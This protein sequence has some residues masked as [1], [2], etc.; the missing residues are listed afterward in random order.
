MTTMNTPETIDQSTE[1]LD[2]LEKAIR[3]RRCLRCGG[4]LFLSRI[5]GAGEWA[6]LQCGRTYPR[7]GRVRQPAGL[8]RPTR[9][10]A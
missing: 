2:Q 5:N 3:A 10:T 7:S 4:N 9:W 1:Q 8:R 6:C